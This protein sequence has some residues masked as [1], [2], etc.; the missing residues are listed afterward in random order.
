VVGSWQL[1]VGSWNAILPR[2]QD[3]AKKAPAQIPSPRHRVSPYGVIV[4]LAIGVVIAIIPV[5]A[6]LSIDA[7]R[8]FALFATVI[9][10]LITEPIP[11]AIIGMVGVI[12]AAM[13]GLV[14]DAP[15]QSAQW[16]LSGFGNA[17]VWLIFAGYMFTLGYTQTGLGRRIALHL[18]RLLGHRTLGLGYAVALADLALA[19]FT[20]SATAR[21]A[22]TVFPVVRQIPELYQSRPH[23]GTARRLGAYLLYTALATSF[24]TSSM[25]V[26]A[27]APNT[28]ALSVMRQTA[29]VTVTWLDWFV[30]FAPVGVVLLLVVPWL[31]YK[32]YPP[33]IRT[34]PEAPRWAAQQLDTMGAMTRKEMT[35]LVLVCAALSLWIGAIEY[36]E[37]AISAMLVVLL[38]VMFKVVSWEEVIGHAQAWNVLVWFATM[39]TLASGLGETKFLEWLAQSMAPTIEGLGLS[40]AIVA[41]VS[42]YFFLHY[43]FASITA[44]AAS[45]LPVF[46]GIAV[47]I[48]GLSPKSWALLLAYP[49]G[50]MGVLTTYTAGHNPIYY[51]SG[52]ITR[53]AFWGL[54]ITLGLFFLVVYLAIAVPWLRYLG[55]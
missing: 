35:L 47:M 17:T 38:M 34:A 31:L 33:E 55:V 8:Y 22:G 29:G 9:V 32:I 11:P 16:A 40:L 43:F 54:G 4:P 13:L 3:V 42:V 25:F 48:P 19:P 24:V 6:G 26:T 12:V 14:R 51:G 10:A 21:S 27:L 5:P 1:G 20:A 52:Y 44:H 28:L 7:W 50:L 36:V 2:L 37:P 18:V 15:A 39:V 49:L 30:G 53:Q 45:M 41:L 23:D 46:I